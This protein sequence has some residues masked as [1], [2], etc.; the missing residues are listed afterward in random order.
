MVGHKIRALKVVSLI[1]TGTH[2]CQFFDNDFIVMPFE[3]DVIHNDLH[4]GQIRN[5]RS[6]VYVRT[7]YRHFQP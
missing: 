5:D 4:R 3:G 7:L 1:D 6:Y 2:N